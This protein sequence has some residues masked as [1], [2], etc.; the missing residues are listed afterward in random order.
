MEQNIF[1]RDAQSFRPLV[2]ATV[3]AIVLMIADWQHPEWFDPARRLTRAALDPLYVFASYPVLSGDWLSEQ[4]QS[5]EVLRRENAAL[6]AERL[7]NNVR[8]QKLAELS[9][10][11]TRLRGLLN[12][13]LIIDGRMIISE[14]IGTDPDP[15]RHILVINRGDVDGVFI[16]QMVL[17]DKGV[18]GQVV[19][20]LAHSARILLISDKENA[21]SVRIER[22]GMRGI[23]AGTGDSGR[24]SLQYVPNTADVQVGDRLFTS[25]LGERFPAGYAVGVVSAIQHHGSSE[26]A[27]IAIKPLAQLEGGHHVILLF[28]APLAKEQPHTEPAKPKSTKQQSSG[29]RY[30]AQ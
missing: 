7:Q 22:T 27:D 25:G 19:E 6:K 29:T 17:D 4:A 9:A 28:S 26:F 1:A 18:V 16:G 3:A 12:T 8:L 30:V 24:L 23:L 2:L 21:V 13:P 20:V 5:E 15:L 10:E 11:N 14:I